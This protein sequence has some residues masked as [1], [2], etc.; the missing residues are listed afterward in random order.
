MRFITSAAVGDKASARGVDVKLRRDSHDI[1][2][3]DMR[4]LDV[5]TGLCAMC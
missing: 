5:L 2:G 4:I 1:D 3:L